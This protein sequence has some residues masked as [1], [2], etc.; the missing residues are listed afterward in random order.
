MLRGHIL[1]RT[2]TARASGPASLQHTV[3]LLLMHNKAGSMGLIINRLLGPATPEDAPPFVEEI[4][5]LKQATGTQPWLFDGGIAAV[6][7]ITVLHQQRDA[8]TDKDVDIGNDRFELFANARHAAQLNPTFIQT[9]KALK[10]EPHGSN[11]TRVFYGHVVWQS[12][13]LDREI[14]EGL[15][16]PA[17]VA[18]ALLFSDT[19]GDKLWAE[20]WD[21]AEEWCEQHLAAAE[22]AAEK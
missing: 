10:H 4:E 14:R 3:V 20:I 6:K 22:V 17:A 16:F 19:S 12:G 5:A 8:M 1:L 11:A 18:P 7:S 21:L 2:N 9:V 13:V 15:W